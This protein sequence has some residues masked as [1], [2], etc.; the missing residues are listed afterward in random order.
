MTNRRPDIHCT[1]CRTYC[2]SLSHIP[3]EQEWPK[4]HSCDACKEHKL[5]K[6]L[7][8]MGYTG[9]DAFTTAFVE[10]GVSSGEMMGICMNKKCNYTTDCEEDAKEN[11]CDECETN[12]L[13]SALVLANLI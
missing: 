13:V 8:D 12:S 10:Q 11:S 2:Y 6:L 9:V 5:A 1:C 4:N 7:Q 3:S